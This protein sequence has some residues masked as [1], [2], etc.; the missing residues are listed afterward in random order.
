MHSCVR[1]DADRT[2]VWNAAGKKPGVCDLMARSFNPEAKV[3]RGSELPTKNKACRCWELRWAT[4]IICQLN[5]KRFWKTTHLL[6]ADPELTRL[7][8][9]VASVA[10]LL[11][12]TGKLSVARVASRR[13][14]EVC[15][16]WVKRERGRNARQ[17][18]MRHLHR[19]ATVAAV[20]HDWTVSG[21]HRIDHDRTCPSNLP[22]MLASGLEFPE[23]VCLP[24]SVLLP[25]VLRGW[26]ASRQTSF[27]IWI[28]RPNPLDMR[29][30][31]VVRPFRG[32]AGLGHHSYCDGS[33]Q[34]KPFWLK[35]FWLKPFGF[36]PFLFKPVSA[37]AG[38]ELFQL[39][40]VIPVKTNLDGPQ[41]EVCV[42]GRPPAGSVE[43]DHERSTASICEVGETQFT[44]SRVFHPEG[45]SF[46]S[47][48]RSVWNPPKC[49]GN[50]CFPTRY[51]QR[52]VR[53]LG[54]SNLF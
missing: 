51:L 26:S 34:P 43:D 10:P 2:Q 32:A 6:A 12:P 5:C 20:N 18:T 25:R 8:I 15:P 31:E 33:P 42:G 39:A 29:R 48:G 53:G 30:L 16:C 50:Q 52:R 45:R 38:Q 24:W 9:G 14:P 41:S 47:L 4:L 3:W 17:N 37:C 22:N 36:K 13:T 28:C 54:S 11:Q 23:G 35:P 27:A 49:N 44:V 7:P 1:I 40:L 46:R 19:M 21:D